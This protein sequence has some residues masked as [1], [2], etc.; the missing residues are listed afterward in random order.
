M[1]NRDKPALSGMENPS[2]AL[3]RPPQPSADANAVEASPPSILRAW[4]YLVGLSIARQARMREMVWIAL[5]LL[6]FS[7]TL[8]A[9]YTATNGWNLPN[10]RFAIFTRDNQRFVYTNREA[11]EY[12]DW[13]LLAAPRSPLTP[14]WEQ[15]VF[16]SAQAALENAPSPV[17][18]QM[19][20]LSGPSLLLNFLLPIWSLS[21]ATDSIGGDRES[22]NLIWLLTRP[23]PRPL[24]YLAKFVSV[25]P[26]TLGLNVGGF[27]LLCL[28]GGRPGRE[29]FVLFWPGICCATLAFSALFLL[30]GTYFRRPAVIAIVYSF[31]LEIILGNMPGYLKRASIG[32]YARC[33][34]YEAVADRQIGPRSPQIFLAVDGGTA[35]AVLVVAT[36]AL[37]VM[38]MIVFTRMEYNEVS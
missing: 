13:L 3:P 8:V 16:A 31:F 32:F 9:I 34:M 30:I 11:M 7:V 14:Q 19:I 38:G 33:M 18:A 6:G 28:A 26:W 20:V 4:L 21:F 5:G 1:A 2:V 23:M 24:I 27:G 25:L 29:A 12:A 10:R 35:F 17:F 36:L 37:L 22:R 15:G